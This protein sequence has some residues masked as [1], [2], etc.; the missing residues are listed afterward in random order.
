MVQVLISHINGIDPITTVPDSQ[1]GGP[2]LGV[3]VSSK[4]M[5]AYIFHSQIILSPIGWVF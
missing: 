5:S 4:G 3:I 1:G 2:V